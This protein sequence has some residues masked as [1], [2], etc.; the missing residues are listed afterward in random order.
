MNQMLNLVAH[1]VSKA[2]G[3]SVPKECWVNKANVCGNSDQYVLFMLVSRIIKCD[4]VHEPLS[5][6]DWG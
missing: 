6:Y 2:A 1:Y 3:S 5:T 4:L